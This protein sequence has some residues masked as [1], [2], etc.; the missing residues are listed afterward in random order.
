[1][2]AHA[3]AGRRRDASLE[4]MVVKRGSDFGRRWGMGGRCN[5]GARSAVRR[6]ED[7]LLVVAVAVAVAVVPAVAG[8]QLV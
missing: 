1:M 4:G 7:R 8:A 2:E 6:I 3:T 5:P